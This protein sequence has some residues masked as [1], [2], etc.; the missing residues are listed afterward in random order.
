MKINKKRGFIVEHPAT[1]YGEPQ[2]DTTHVLFCKEC[3]V[4]RY[5]DKRFVESVEHVK[6]LGLAEDGH[7]TP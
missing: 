6:Q 2:P 3:R 7:T 1:F 5:V 4:A